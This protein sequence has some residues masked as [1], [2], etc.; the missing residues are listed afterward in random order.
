M[1]AEN[2]YRLGCNC[3]RCSGAH[4]YST[5]D[6]KNKASELHGGRYSYEHT[7]YINAHTHILIT[8]K[9][10][11]VFEQS[12]TAHLSG[13]GCRRCSSEL[14]SKRQITSL[15]NFITKARKVQTGWDYS[16]VDYKGSH[17]KVKMTC[18]NGHIVWQ[19]PTGHLSGRNCKH[20]S[21]IDS[22]GFLNWTTIDRDQELAEVP[23]NFY[24][25]KLKDMITQEEFYKVGITTNPDSRFNSFGDYKVINTI[26]LQKGS[27]R[28]VFDL[29]RLVLDELNNSGSRYIPSKK[30]GGHTECFTLNLEA[31]Y[32]L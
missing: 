28:D 7:N 12:P 1:K 22:S 15:D 20:C 9:S 14:S 30:F 3:P 32:E 8:C 16:E 29:E 26:L 19:S 18:R 2:H 6:F 4:R 17:A 11:G 5:E 13:K 23:N 24:F 27:T 10:H 25:I 21:A 31:A